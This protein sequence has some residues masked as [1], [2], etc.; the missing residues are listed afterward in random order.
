VPS[1]SPL[2]LG[3]FALSGIHA[4]NLA[5]GPLSHSPAYAI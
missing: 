3:S 4:R 2:P 1:R 5:L